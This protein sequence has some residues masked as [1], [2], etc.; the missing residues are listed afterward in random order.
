MRCTASQLQ[1]LAL[2]DDTVVVEDEAGA[3]HVALHKAQAW[4]RVAAARAG[5]LADAATSLQALASFEASYPSY[6][7]ASTT[8]GLTAAGQV[9]RAGAAA[10]GCHGAGCRVQAASG[11]LQ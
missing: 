6:S 7:D 4:G 9:S 3:L 8:G 5:L 2:R 10:C 11:L 1:E